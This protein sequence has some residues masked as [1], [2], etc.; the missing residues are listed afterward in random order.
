MHNPLGQLLDTAAI[1]RYHRRRIQK[2]G[3]GGPGALGWAG[4]EGQQARFQVLTQIGDLAHHSVLD[5][6]CGYADLYPFLQQRYAGVRYHGIEQMPELLAV[7]RARYRD[8]A[9]I[10][11]SSSDFLRTPLPPADYVLASGALNYRHRDPQFIYQAI[12][13][14]FGGCQ[15]GLGFNLL[16]WEPAGGGPLAAYDPAGILAFCQ[17]LASRAELLEG[18]WEGDF[19]VFM[20]R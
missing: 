10:T 16:S 9:G 20:Y 4:A 18:Y 15:L 1:F 13:K 6:G 2:Y 8:A 17:T 5:A 14:L 19:T 7:A 12:E 11:L 3:S